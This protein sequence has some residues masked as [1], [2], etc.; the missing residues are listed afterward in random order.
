MHHLPPNLP[1]CVRDELKLE[2]HPGLLCLGSYNS[3]S[4]A[5]SPSGVDENVVKATIH[6]P[7][8]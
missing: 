8:T 1:E 2:Q 7:F 6:L 5:G 4:I 3:D